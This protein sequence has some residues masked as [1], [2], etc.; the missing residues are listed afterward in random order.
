VQVNQR[1]FTNEARRRQIVAAA[2]TTIAELGFQRTSFAQIA[3]RAGLSS[4]RMIS[5]HFAGKD[6]LLEAVVSEAFALAGD[7]IEPFVMSRPTP[8]GQLRGFIEGNARFYAA[9]RTHVLAVRDIFYGLRKPDG[10]RRYGAE[11]FELE[12]DVVSQIL[13]AGQDSGEFR[14]FDPRFMAR[15]LRHALD[16]LAE[17]IA[18]DPEI[19]LDACIEEFTAIFDGATRRAR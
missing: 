2:V 12:I 19:D 16:G 10:T 3:D 17:Q 14:D 1:S 6:D 8:A 18:A 9:H 11:A 5:Y 4:T 7:F 13:R 15:T